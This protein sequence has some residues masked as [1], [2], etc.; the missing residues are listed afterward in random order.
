MVLN[1]PEDHN[2]PDMQ[3]DGFEA[4]KHSSSADVD[5]EEEPGTKTKS[6][7]PGDKSHKYEILFIMNHQFVDGISG[8]DLIYNQFLP[9]LN[10]IINNLPV[11]DIFLTPHDVT[12]SYEEDILGQVSTADKKPAWYVKAFFNL[13][14]AKNRAFGGNDGRIKI[15]AEGS[16]FL[17]QKGMGIFKFC[18]QEELVARIL[19]E[20]K[21]NDVTVHSILV[22]G[23]SF[24]VIKL[25]QDLGQPLPKKIESAW[26]IDS[27][28]KLAK[29]KSPQPLGMFISPIGMTSM[30]VPRPY[31]F[32]REVFWHAA[33]HISQ[34]VRK[35]V[36]NQHEG[37]FLD[38]MS[39][40]YNNHNV[41]DP[42]TIIQE[43]G[44][45]THFDISN[46]GKCS[47]RPQLDATL[48][49]LIDAD[50]I[51]FGELGQGAP[52]NPTP[53]F[54]TVV[55]HKGKLFIVSCYNK[56][57]VTRELAGKLMKYLEEVLDGV[58]RSPKKD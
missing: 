1:M 46:L 2:A 44:L 26:P 48:P 31:E 12:P 5:K 13:Q 32:N 28:K 23:L 20:R 21:A 41:A 52:N 47:S 3:G 8:H 11:D 43:T 58:C 38:L 40:L 55:T 45:L 51:Y 17:D 4:S 29:F 37:L 57:W 9:I 7:D 49:K 36:Q 39:Y 25:L 6:H 22:T 33:A 30:K 53:F 16:P 14:R 35:G 50:E 24:A 56:R 10:K 19:Y 18:L 15:T 34:Q 42:G 27:R 54:N